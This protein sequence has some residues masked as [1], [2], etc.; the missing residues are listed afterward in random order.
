[1]KMKQVSLRF[2]VA[3][4]RVVVRCPVLQLEQRISVGVGVAEVAGLGVDDARQA[5]APG[6]GHVEERPAEAAPEEAVEEKVGGGVQ[7]LGDLADEGEDDEELVVA[8]ELEAERVLDGQEG[9]GEEED[10][11]DGHDGEREAS[12]Q[13]LGGRLQHA[14]ATRH[15]GPHHPA[16]SRLQ[17]T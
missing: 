4:G 2:A 1:M 7:D 6:H 16:P 17:Q 10:E 3:V 5:T 11:G 12:A 13:V 15:A 9:V 8:F 14:R